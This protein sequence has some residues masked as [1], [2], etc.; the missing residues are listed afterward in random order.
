VLYWLTDV[1]FWNCFCYFV[2]SIFLPLFPVSLSRKSGWTAL[3]VCL[4]LRFSVLYRVFMPAG[5]EGHERSVRVALQTLQVRRSSY[6]CFEI[7]DDPCDLICFQQRDLFTNRNSFC[8]KFDLFSI[9]HTKWD[10]K[11]FLFRFL[12]NPLL[13]YWYTGQN[14]VFNSGS[15]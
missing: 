1:E 4:L 6:I 11:L 13:D 2:F 15:M 14:P 5:S 7:K 10:V 3:F 12:T 9:L 8:S